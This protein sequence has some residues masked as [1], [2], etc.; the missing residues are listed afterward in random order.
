MHKLLIVSPRFPPTNAADLHRI[1]VSLPHYAS[2][3]WDATILCVDHATADGI[4][5]PS[6]TESVPGG[7]RI[8]RVN[9]WSEAIC[10]RFGFGTLGY[11]SLIP[12]YCAARRL[13]RRERYDV[14]FFSTTV[15]LAFVLGPLWKRRYGC[16]IVYDFHDPWYRGPL[17]RRAKVPG[18]WWKYRL[19]QWLAGHLERFAL[20]AADHIVSVSAQ[21][22]LALSRRY[23]WL[24]RSM[25]T[26]LP[27]AAAADDYKFARKHCVVQHIFKRDGRFIRWIYVGAMGQDMIPVLE[28]L[29]RAVGRLR[30]DDPEFASRLRLHFVGTNYAPAARS[31]KLVE[32]LAAVCGLADMVEEIAER[33]PYFEAISLYA[34]CDAVLL[35]GSIHADYTASKLLNC[36][37][38]K[39]PILALF[40]RESLVSSIA[41]QFPNVFL[42]TFER[43]PEEPEFIERVIEGMAWLRSARFDAAAIDERLRPW[44]AEEMTRR[45][46]VIFDGLAARALEITT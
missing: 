8:V 32:P 16:R 28:V 40:H 9:A 20:T 41:A 6:L 35:I 30:N 25:F 31:H 37:L 1:R 22:T 26:V 36:V 4:C 42:A 24:D 34:D 15:F 39:K 13:L 45:Q 12:L 18:K 46:C 10:R 19:D 21:Y 17:H 23:S 5:D 33:I 14:V 7:L 43:A 27:F 2:F 3:G 11:R 44:S 29:F 38:A